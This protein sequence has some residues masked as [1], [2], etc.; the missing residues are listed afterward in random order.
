MP[1]NLADLHVMF[2]SLTQSKLPSSAIAFV[3]GMEHGECGGREV[4]DRDQTEQFKLHGINMTPDTYHAFEMG[5]KVGR[6]K[7]TVTNMRNGGGMG[8]M[9]GSGGFRDTPR[10]L[11]HE[12]WGDDRK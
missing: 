8:G 11:P 7:T 10:D 4:C 12:P 6:L 3:L 5:A 2:T 9:G 1:I